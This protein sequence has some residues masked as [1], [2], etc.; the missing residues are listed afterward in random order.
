[1]AALLAVTAA[2]GSPAP[3]HTTSSST[4]GAGGA[5]GGFPQETTPRAD[6]VPKATGACPDF[7][8]GK[9]TF[10]PDGTSRDALIWVDPAKAQASDGP[11]VFFW[12]GTGGDPSE[13]GGALGPAIAA[14]KNMG[15]VVA[16]PYPAPNAG[17][18]PW[19]LMLGG[20]NEN[21][22]RLADEILAC[23]GAKVGIDMR[24]IYS[25]GFSAGAMNT[26]QFAAR[27][28]GYL[29]AIVAY[30]GA[31]LGPVDEQDPANLYPAMLF[32]GGP[33]DQVSVNFADQTKLYHDT[34]VSE[35]HFAFMCNHGQ[36]HTVPSSGPASAWQFLLDHPFGVRPEPY[37]AGLPKGFPVYCAL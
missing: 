16:A 20:T 36:G 35:G 13:A 26:E 30:S 33:S 28:S 5:G 22:L 2:C 6:L 1:M 24:R 37:A 14:V 21:D 27:R 23:A 12:H 19:S 31:R 18:F 4:G 11:L 10:T 17:V 3:A 15:G 8:E 7:A 34:L 25:V 9:A 29:A 32:Y